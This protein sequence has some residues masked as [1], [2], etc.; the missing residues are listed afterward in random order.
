M[1]TSGSPLALAAL[2]V[3][4]VGVA[5]AVSGNGISSKDPARV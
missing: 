4:G 1:R 2:T 5:P 3:L